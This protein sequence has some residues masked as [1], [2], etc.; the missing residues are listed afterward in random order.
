MGQARRR[1]VVAQV[2]PQLRGDAGARASAAALDDM[3]LDQLEELAV[4]RALDRYSGH[5]QLAAAARD[6]GI[7]WTALYRRLEKYGIAV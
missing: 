7:S 1:D 2:G 6:L 3:T 5:G 4:R